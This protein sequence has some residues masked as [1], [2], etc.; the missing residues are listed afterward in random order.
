MNADKDNESAQDPARPHPLLRLGFTGVAPEYPQPPHRKMTQQVLPNLF[1]PGCE[2]P[3]VGR[4]VLRP[5]E[6]RR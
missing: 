5:T 2:P 1:G 6:H 4:T 3:R